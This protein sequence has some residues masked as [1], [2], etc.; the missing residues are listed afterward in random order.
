MLT[1]TQDFGWLYTEALYVTPF[2]S[3]DLDDRRYL[4]TNY[5]RTRSCVLSAGIPETGYVLVNQQPY[6]FGDDFPVILGLMDEV[7]D[8]SPFTEVL[9]PAATL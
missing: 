7:D 4:V 8:N 3:P 5:D 9:I 1:Q 2:G 6:D